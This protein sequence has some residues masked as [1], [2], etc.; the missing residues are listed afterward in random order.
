[1][2]NIPIE[3]HDEDSFSSDAEFDEYDEGSETSTD[4]DAKVAEDDVFDIEFFKCYSALKKKDEKIYDKNVKF[5]SKYP[6]SDSENE[7]DEESLEGANKKTTAPKMTLLDH[8]LNLKDEEIEEPAKIDLNRPVSKSF[9][10]KELDEIKKSI[11]KVSENVDSESDDDLLIVKK[12]EVE[13][14]KSRPKKKIDA[15]LDKL[16]KD[17]HQ[18][19]SHLKQLWS[20]PKLTEEEKY[21]RD[22]ILNKR[23][24]NKEKSSSD[25]DDAGNQ[26]RFFSKN[27]DELSD[28][29]EEE[30][31]TKTKRK[32]DHRSDEKDFDKIARIPRNSTKTIRD[33]AEKREKKEKRMKRVEKEKKRKKGLRDADCEDI[34]GGL[35]TKFHYRET[36]PIDYGLSAMELLMAT[37]EELDK[38][39]SLKDTIS[40]KTREEELADKSRYEKKRNDLELKKKILKSIY[41]EDESDGQIERQNDMHKGKEP[42]K[43]KQSAKGEI[44]KVKSDDDLEEI[45]ESNESSNKRKKKHK[46]GTN[47]KKFAKAGIA[48]DRLLS[49]G[50]SKTKLRKSKLL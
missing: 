11:E 9:Y 1:M 23:Y 29:E 21:L 14:S 20:D 13:P 19:I 41:G 18:D 44:E 3:E 24:L 34:V 2:A 39:I 49:Y 31:K 42:K 38:W 36:E 43:A 40:Y 6:T 4:V 47:H 32:A 8:Q 26:E 10:E 30:A 17:D 50:L 12:S 37:D 45:K 27:L 5:F 7:H 35:P 46:R 28:V 16:E 22:Y 33:L 15:L 25:E 48:P